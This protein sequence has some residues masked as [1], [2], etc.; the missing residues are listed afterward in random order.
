MLDTRI[1]SIQKAAT[2]PSRPRHGFCQVAYDG[3]IFTYRIAK[4]E[5]ARFEQFLAENTHGARVAGTWPRYAY[6][7]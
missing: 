3:Y 4:Q 6:A 7:A 2:A 1:V 5:R